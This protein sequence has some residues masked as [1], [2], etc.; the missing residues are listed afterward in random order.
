M[1]RS[2]KSSFRP[3]RT[4]LR[5]FQFQ[6]NLNPARC[7]RR[8]VSGWTRNKAL[9]HPGHR[10]RRVTQNNRSGRE[11]RGWGWRCARIASCCRRAR[12]S[13][14]RRRRDRTERMSATNKSLSMRGMAGL[15]HRKHNRIEPDGVL[16][17]DRYKRSGRPYCGL[18][19][20]RICRR[21]SFVVPCCDTNQHC[22][23]SVFSYLLQAQS[24]F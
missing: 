1:S 10:R 2:L 11:N 20:C 9:R 5:E 3:T 7:Q 24:Y 6:Y 23:S 4:R 13:K 19:D 22:A 12:F 18:Q 15:Y 14:R 21:P 17:R 8:M 16:A